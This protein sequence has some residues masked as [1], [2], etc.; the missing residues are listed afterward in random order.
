MSRPLISVIF[1]VF[2]GTS[3]LKEAVESI[4]NQ[5]F[6]DF[7]FIIVDDGSTDQTPKILDEFTD[8]RI[9]RLKNGKNLGLVKSLNKALGVAQGE[10]VARMDA[11]DVSLPERFAKQVAY[12]KQH[13]QIGVLGTA[14]SQIDKKGQFISILVPPAHHSLILWQMFF[15]CSIF[16]PTV[17]MRKSILNDIGYYNINFIHTEDIE[18]WSRLFNKTKFANLTEVLYVRRLHSRSIISTQSAVQYQKGI[19]V[20]QRLLKLV[21]G[22]DV[23]TDLVA[24][25]LRP[26]RSL[27]RKRRIATLDLLLELYDKILQLDSVSIEDKKF[28]Q[29]DLVYR[30]TLIHQG[31]PRF[32]L[33][34]LILCLSKILPISLRHKMKVFLNKYQKG[35]LLEK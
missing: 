18:L 29:A 23:L 32:F 14:M 15:G 33:R 11:D 8:K 24:W 9:V 16:H 26:D 28:L 6:T 30:I 21:L 13:L 4:L 35:F 34:R 7:E 2:N 19:I 22:Y 17:M 10:F 25:F 5:T 1:S 31:W 27:G 20:R 12:L 3:Y